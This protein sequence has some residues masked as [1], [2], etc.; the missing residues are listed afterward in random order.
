MVSPDFIL[1]LTGFKGGKGKSKKQDLTPFLSHDPIPLT[2]ALATWI[3]LNWDRS[4]EKRWF[5]RYYN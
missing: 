2:K 5:L 1:S 4:F 3:E